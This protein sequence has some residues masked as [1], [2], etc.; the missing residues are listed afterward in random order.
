MKDGGWNVLVGCVFKWNDQGRKAKKKASKEKQR[1]GT[2]S[3][4]NSKQHSPKINSTKAERTKEGNKG[5]I[6]LRS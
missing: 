2:T 5:Q 3:A 6:T 1:R 4:N